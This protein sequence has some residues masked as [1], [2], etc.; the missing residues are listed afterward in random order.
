[1]ILDLLASPRLICSPPSLS[2]DASRSRPAIAAPCTPPQY[3]PGMWQHTVP[4]DCAQART[5]G[6]AIVS[7]PLQCML[8]K[9]AAQISKGA[10]GH[11]SGRRRVACVAVQKG[12][13]GSVHAVKLGCQAGVPNMLLPPCPPQ[14]PVPAASLLR[15][16]G[17]EL[18]AE[19]G[20]RQALCLC[21][22]VAG[23]R[24][25]GGHAPHALCAFARGLQ[26]R[27]GKGC[28]DGRGRG[29]AA[30]DTAERRS[31]PSFAYSAGL[32]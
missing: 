25:G 24:H 22:R 14:P 30:L 31:A 21:L 28:V 12:A 17:R 7:H 15:Q 26:Y 9:C 20:R 2:R 13:K 11:R 6:A 1:M 4:G 16:Q 10:G 5:A 18:A 29:G 27:S 19:D 8:T 32:A 23:T 3:A